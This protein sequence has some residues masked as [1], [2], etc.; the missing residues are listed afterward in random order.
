LSTI[1]G[2]MAT[3]PAE[4]MACTMP[5]SLLLLVYLSGSFRKS[6]GTARPSVLFLIT[7][8]AVTFPT[9]WL[10]PGAKG[11]YFMPLY[12]CLAPLIGLVIQRCAASTAP[13]D[14]FRAWRWYCLA[15]AALMVTA[16]GLIA[17]VNGLPVPRPASLTQPPLFA[18]A[19]GVAALVLSAL[20]VWACRPGGSRRVF[21]A[22][23][24]VACF[25]GLTSTG[26]V[27]NYQQ[28][29]SVGAAEEM[30]RLKEK[31]P[32]G[33]RLISLGPVHH[34]FAYH[35][36]APIVQRAWPAM[37]PGGDEEAAYLCFDHWRGK[38][39]LLPF[40]WEPVGTVCCDRYRSR[41]P[42]VVVVV[43]R[44]LGGGVASRA[45]GTSDPIGRPT[46]R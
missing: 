33:Q 8:L 40:A 31:L 35:Y 5:W 2:H 3:Y 15:L 22:V 44:R 1:A 34:R 7:C 10:V 25:L 46:S 19:Y 38:A 45:V 16:A 20:L 32:P 29:K 6:L 4:V 39:P 23:G 43:G 18:A 36:G 9:C 42:E 11:R 26:V 37:N 12:P 30:A 13:A 41:R 21:V 27:L 28:S 14:L 24:A 17:G